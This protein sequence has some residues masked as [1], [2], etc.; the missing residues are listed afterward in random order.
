MQDKYHSLTKDI[1]RDS[2]YQMLVEPR[3]KALEEIGA[4]YYNVVDSKLVE[5][6]GMKKDSPIFYDTKEFHTINDRTDDDAWGGQ[7]TTDIVTFDPLMSQDDIDAKKAQ[8]KQQAFLDQMIKVVDEELG[9]EVE[10]KTES[11]NAKDKNDDDVECYFILNE[12]ATVDDKDA[13]IEF[14]NGSSL[15]IYLTESSEE[16]AHIKGFVLAN[17]SSTD[18]SIKL[19]IDSGDVVLENKTMII[20]KDSEEVGCINL[21]LRDATTD[22]AFSEEVLPLTVAEDVTVEVT[23]ILE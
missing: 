1:F 4:V 3:N 6:D 18:Y 23:P 11:I 10:W 16:P 14:I 17:E 8:N 2:T 9:N 5:H 19:E 21:S 22:E 7:T 15:D 13:I 20:Y 12:L